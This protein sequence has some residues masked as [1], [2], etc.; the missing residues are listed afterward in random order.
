MSAQVDRLAGL[1]LLSIL[2][3]AE[4]ALAYE[5]GPV[6]GGGTIGGQVRVT[7]DVTPLA[8]QRVYKHVKEC[9]ETVRDDRLVLGRDGALQYV[10]VSLDGVT[11]GKPLPSG[12]VENFTRSIG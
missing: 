4:P 3:G 9:G 12:V 2:A 8:P 6:T 11:K 10:V 5:G 1:L 7:G